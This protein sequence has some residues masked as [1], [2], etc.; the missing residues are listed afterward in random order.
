MLLIKKFIRIYHIIFMS[1]YLLWTMCIKINTYML[2]TIFMRSAGD[3]KELIKPFLCY[4]STSTECMKTIRSFTMTESFS[5]IEPV[6]RYDK[7][8]IFKIG[9]RQFTSKQTVGHM[10]ELRKKSKDDEVLKDKV[11]VLKY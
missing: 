10:T 7:Q 2:K 1:L 4:P 9:Y 5:A 6:Q 11:M 8:C 3:L